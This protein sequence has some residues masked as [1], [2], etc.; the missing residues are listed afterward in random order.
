MSTKGETGVV[1]ANDAQGRVN[2]AIRCQGEGCNNRADYFI[3]SLKRELEARSKW[4]WVCNQCEKLIAEENILIINMARARL[5]TVADYIESI[6]ER[7]VGRQTELTIHASGRSAA[8]YAVCDFAG[9][10][11]IDDKQLI[12]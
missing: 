4:L 10:P 5:M 3:G 11:C 12:D 7:Y 2:R 9:K 8:E 6:M 1:K